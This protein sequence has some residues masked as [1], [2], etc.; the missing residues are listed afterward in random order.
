MQHVD[1]SSG[2][3]AK[4]SIVEQM[5]NIGSE[6]IRAL[7]WRKKNMVFAQAANVR[8]LELFDLSLGASVSPGYLKEIARARELWLDFFFGS[9]RDHQT[10]HQWEKYFMAFT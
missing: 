9:N 8:A 3:W 7:K 1:L 10:E 2:R 5:A 4:L 6:V